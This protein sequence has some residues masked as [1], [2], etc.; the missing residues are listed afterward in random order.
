MIIIEHSRLINL[1]TMK[2]IVGTSV[3]QA[4]KRNM[5]SPRY[6]W[7]IYGWYAQASWTNADIVNCT[8][9]QLQTVL[10]N[11]ISV[12]VFP[13]P[14]AENI[15]TISG[16]VSMWTNFKFLLRKSLK[17]NHICPNNIDQYSLDR[18][19]INH[20]ELLY[21]L[22]FYKPYYCSQNPIYTWHLQFEKQLCM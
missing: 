16:K 8:V 11:G 4:F 15:T 17:P 5:T 9:E 6:V 19:A 22:A 2:I 3:T 20:K 7:I 1:Q 18:L 12:E 10:N 14:E 13:I 21:Y